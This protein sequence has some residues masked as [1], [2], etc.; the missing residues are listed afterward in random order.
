MANIQNQIRKFR[1]SDGGNGDDA[2]FTNKE[3]NARQVG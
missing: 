1:V 2:M 3:I